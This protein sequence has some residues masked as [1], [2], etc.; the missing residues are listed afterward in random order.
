MSHPGSFAD[1]AV[2]GLGPAGRTLAHRAAAAGL[3]VVA[4][5]PHPRRRWSPTYAA[6]VDELPDWLD[7]SVFGSRVERPSVWTLHERR[8]ERAYGVFDNEALQSTLDLDAVRVVPGRADRLSAHSIVLADGTEVRARV[9]VDARGV[10]AHPALAEQTAYGLVVSAAAAAPA[11]GGAQ[12]WFMD[13]RRDN[14]AGRDD[15]PSFLY[16]VPLDDERYLLE[17]TCLVG[18][19]GLSQAVLKYRLHQRLRARRVPVPADADRERV[20][21]PV[22]APNSASATPRFGAAAG[23]IHPGTGYSVAASLSAADSVVRSTVDG[24]DVESSLWPVRARAVRGLRDVGLR[25]LLRLEP[26]YLPV[27]FDTFFALP[28]QDQRNYLSARADPVAVSSTMWALF[29]RV[30]APVRRT[31]A[32]AALPARRR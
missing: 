17:E 7:P 3:D 8:L 29:R 2:V 19:P 11:L 20:R 32:A 21:F 14:G 4:V 6:W 27:F 1:L 9:V 24:T 16:A 18:R 10:R 28:D 15:P 12:A 26:R 31:M 5:D 25:A 30:P 22:Q 23:L 13:W